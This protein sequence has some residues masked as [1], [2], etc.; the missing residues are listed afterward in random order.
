MESNKEEQNVENVFCDW[1][2]I[3]SIWQ[4]QRIAET[5]QD[6]T[7]AETSRLKSGKCV[8]QNLYGEMIYSKQDRPTYLVG[9]KVAFHNTNEKYS[10][11]VTQRR[12]GLNK[13]LLSMR[14]RIRTPLP[15]VWLIWWKDPWTAP[16]TNMKC[17][18]P[19]RLRF[20]SK[21]WFDGIQKSKSRWWNGRI[22]QTNSTRGWNWVNWK[23]SS[24]RHFRQVI[25]WKLNNTKLS[26]TDTSC[27]T[28][29]HMHYFIQ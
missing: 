10:T 16:F 2:T 14:F 12:V 13:S 27:T 25:N 9:D 22:I 8:Y 26:K 5:I 21:K 4:N 1:I 18:K 20:E 11:R 3:L 24:D 19:N 23:N 29:S 6:M 15:T 7:S 28:I 17:W